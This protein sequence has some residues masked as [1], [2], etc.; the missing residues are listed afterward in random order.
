MNYKIS[1][2]A[3]YMFNSRIS[4]KITVVFGLMMLP[5]Q[6]CTVFQKD[7][8]ILLHFQVLMGLFL[9]SFKLE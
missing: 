8:I 1:K 4:T 2:V 9:G 5:L 3:F 6:G 7:N